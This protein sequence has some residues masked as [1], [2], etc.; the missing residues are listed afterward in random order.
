MSQDRYHPSVI[1]FLKPPSVQFRSFMSPAISTG[2]THT[3]N[4]TNNKH[5]PDH[6]RSYRS[7]SS[8]SP[9]YSIITSKPSPPP[10]SPPLHPSHPSMSRQKLLRRTQPLH[11]P[12]PP[13]TLTRPTPSL[14]YP[15]Y[16]TLLRL[17][18]AAYPSRTL[19][20]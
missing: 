1:T 11:C 19:S 3:Q 9:F 20:P 6:E 18:T 13:P 14:K 8:H 10:P 12:P 5:E 15:H 2:N 4:R 17:Q 16:P 7:E